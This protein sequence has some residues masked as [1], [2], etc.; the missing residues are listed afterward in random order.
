MAQFM[1]WF[2]I[3][4]HVRFVSHGCSFCYLSQSTHSLDLHSLYILS[5]DIWFQDIGS[6]IFSTGSRIFQHCS[7]YFLVR[8]WYYISTYISAT[9]IVLCHFSASITA[10][11]DPPPRNSLVVLW[12]FLCTDGQG[13]RR[14][15]KIAHRNN[16]ESFTNYLPTKCIPA[17]TSVGSS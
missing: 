9:P 5:L 4:T 1:H 2:C 15:K 7:E 8:T 11:N 6:R 16:W 14:L 12:F 13:Q 10:E 3:H 17:L